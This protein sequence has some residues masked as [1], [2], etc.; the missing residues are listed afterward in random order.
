LRFITVGPGQPSIAAECRWKARVQP[1]FS[2]R[3]VA[4]ALVRSV[5]KKVWRSTPRRSVFKR[6]GLPVRVKKTRQVK[7]LEPRFDSIETEKA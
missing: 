5:L 6:S 2:A 4:T 7:K 1:G 3:H